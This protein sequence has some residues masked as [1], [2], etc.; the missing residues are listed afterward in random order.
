MTT[1]SQINI[2]N[3][4]K[5]KTAM[6]NVQSNVLVN[7]AINEDINAPID[8]QNK[9]SSYNILEDN[10]TTLKTYD[11]NEKLYDAGNL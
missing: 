5:L 2:N 11:C 6:K 4:Q 7:L 3:S 9:R 10:R 8:L 1:K